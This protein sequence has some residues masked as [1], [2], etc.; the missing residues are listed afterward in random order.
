[1]S[2]LANHFGVSDFFS[3]F[4]RD[5]FEADEEEGVGVFDAFASAVGRVADALAEP[6]KFVRVGIVP[7]LVEVWVLVELAVLEHLTGG[8]VEEGK[9]PLVDNGRW[10]CAPGGG[11]S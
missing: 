5:I 6:D 3:A 7:D 4:S 11:M 1:M 10:I 8:L 2:N 9:V